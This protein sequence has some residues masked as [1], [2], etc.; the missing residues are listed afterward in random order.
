MVAAQRRLQADP[1]RTGAGSG[2]D[3]RAQARFARNSAIMEKESRQ[4]R[5]CCCPLRTLRAPTGY[6]GVQVGMLREATPLC[7]WN[8]IHLALA[9][10]RFL[11]GSD[12]M[13]RKLA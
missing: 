3:A 7:G 10:T 5:R 1:K 8:T 11:T 6:F 4:S 2:S 13:R 12:E 9:C